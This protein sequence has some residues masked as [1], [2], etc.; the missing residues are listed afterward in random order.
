[1]VENFDAPHFSTF[2]SMNCL[3][4]SVSRRVTR[5]PRR[6]CWLWCGRISSLPGLLLRAKGLRPGALRSSGSRRVPNVRPLQSSDPGCAL[7]RRAA[8]PKVL[9]SSCWVVRILCVRLA[10]L[11]AEGGI[12][13]SQPV[14]R[15]PQGEREAMSSTDETASAR[16]G[17]SSA[18]EKPPVERTPQEPEHKEGEAQAPTAR[19]FDTETNPASAPETACTRDSHGNAPK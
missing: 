19:S 12:K 7:S 9:I 2:R 16:L 17:A 11:L 6:A 18:Q 8:Q 13:P 4:N 10:A 5:Q 3:R 15:K 14:N 1:M